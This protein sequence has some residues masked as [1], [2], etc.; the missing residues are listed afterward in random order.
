MTQ[1][2]QL[3]RN[4]AGIKDILAMALYSQKLIMLMVTQ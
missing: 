1:E 2:V 4:A 3:A